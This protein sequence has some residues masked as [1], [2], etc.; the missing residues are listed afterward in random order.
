VAGDSKIYFVSK[1]GKVSV[2]RAGAK[3][4]TLSSGDLAE[5]DIATP[6]IAGGRI[7]VRTE[8]TLYCFGAK[9]SSRP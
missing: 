1:E 4:Q 6:A 3:W 2:I 5:Q 9:R 7:Y 8:S